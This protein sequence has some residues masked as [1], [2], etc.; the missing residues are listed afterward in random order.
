IL[1]KDVSMLRIYTPGDE[2]EMVSANIDGEQYAIDDNMVGR[3]LGPF[4]MLV[5]NIMIGHSVY[6]TVNISLVIETVPDQTDMP[7]ALSF[8]GPGM[9]MEEYQPIYYY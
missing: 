6:G 2:Y 3:G 7:V 8:G 1:V 9:A 5:A 4:D